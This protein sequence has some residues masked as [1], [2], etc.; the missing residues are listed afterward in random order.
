M[1][2]N[3]L[4]PI[5]SAE[6][7]AKTSVR[8]GEK[9]A[10]EVL[11]ENADK[12]PAALKAAGVSHAII[13]IPE[14]IGPR[15]NLGRAGAALAPDAFLS[16]FLNVQVNRYLDF[17]RVAIAG[18]VACDDLQKESNQAPLNELRSLCASLDERVQAAVTD[19][20]EAGLKPI[21]IGGGN[22]NSLPTIRGVCS[23]AGIENGINCVN[24][25]PHADYRILEGRHSGNPFS[26]AKKENLLASYLVFCLHESYNSEEMLSRLENDG[27]GSISFD[28]LNREGGDSFE[29]AL[30]N[31]RDYFNK[32]KSGSGI[33]LGLELD[34]DSI[35]NM[36][37][38]ALTPVGLTEEEAL[39]YIHFMTENFDTLYLHLSEGAP[40][41]TTDDGTRIVGKFLT[42]AVIT[43]LKSEQKKAL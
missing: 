2:H 21:V 33:N 27:F 11:I 19:I 25:D 17:S 32:G 5:G 7:K 20:V 15:A 23:A 28:A 18:K 43:Y 13:L 40:S 37:T 36:P 42:S 3:F 4:E 41:C 14:D 22:N 24:C 10:G 39:R 1:P 34:L 31:C 30:L 6:I 16:Y 8:P 29:Q 12:S 38:S 26:Y 35:K 9:K